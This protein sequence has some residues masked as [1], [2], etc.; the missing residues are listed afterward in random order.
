[1]AV[2][3]VGILYM[4]KDIGIALPCFGS[5]SG[6]IL[7]LYRYTKVTIIIATLSACIASAEKNIL[8][9]EHGNKTCF[10][11]TKNLYF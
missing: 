1:M 9:S 2:S 8:K 5:I 4:D 7:S 10:L 6:A 11:F 3:F